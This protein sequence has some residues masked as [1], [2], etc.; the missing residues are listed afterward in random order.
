MADPQNV[1]SSNSF[2]SAR[3]P[4]EAPPE[5]LVVRPA[6][7]VHVPRGSAPVCAG[8]PA[9]SLGRLEADACFPLL[10]ESDVPVSSSIGDLDPAGERARTALQEFREA[11]EA[12]LAGPPPEARAANRTI[13]PMP[14]FSFE[15]PFPQLVFREDGK[16]IRDGAGRGS[17][18]VVIRDHDRAR[19]T[20]PGLTVSLPDPLA[21]V[22]AVLLDAARTSGL[23]AAFAEAGR[24]RKP[25]K[26]V[27]PECPVSPAEAER[28]ARA[29]AKALGVPSAAVSPPGEG[30]HKQPIR[31]RLLRHLLD[32]AG[33]P[34]AAFPDACA[35]GLPLGDETRIWP[36]GLWPPKDA[37]EDWPIAGSDDTILWAE[38]YRSVTVHEDRCAQSLRSDE[39]TGCVS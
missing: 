33:D 5:T 11:S 36:S 14:P 20:A 21:Q 10:T 17:P 27:L 29:V 22:R 16:P 24:E 32:C 38:N 13:R 19:G 3:R 15:N 34:D 9:D 18:L 6:L 12:L 4:S 39:W 26:T 30:T 25:V 28:V 7:A 8:V 37:E 2:S 1:L 35:K 23:A 31:L